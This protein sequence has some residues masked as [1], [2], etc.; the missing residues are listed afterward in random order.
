MIQLSKSGQG[1]VRAG[2][3][4]LNHVLFFVKTTEFCK[5]RLVPAARALASGNGNES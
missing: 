4:I 1:K 3:A 5:D 2:K